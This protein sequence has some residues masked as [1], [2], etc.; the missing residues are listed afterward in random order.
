MRSNT[1]ACTPDS[2]DFFLVL[3]AGFTPNWASNG[4]QCLLI[5]KTG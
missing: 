2:P 4:M 1:G 3:F 5:L